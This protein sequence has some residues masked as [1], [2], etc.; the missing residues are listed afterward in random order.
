MND[1]Y[2]QLQNRFNDCHDQSFSLPQNRGN[3]YFRSVCPRKG[4]L[5]LIEE[6]RLRQN[7]SVRSSNMLLPLG[8]SYCLS[9]HVNWSIRERDMHFTTRRGQCEF[10]YSTTTDGDA[11][12]IADEPVMVVNIMLC[13]NLLRSYFESFDL[14]CQ[15]TEIPGLPLGTEKVIYRKHSF[16]SCSQQLLRNLMRT[17]CQRMADKLRIQGKVLELVAFLLDQ[18]DLTPHVIDNNSEDNFA[19]DDD[20]AMISRAK[21]ILRSNLQSPPSLRRLARLVGTNETKLKRRFV[22]LCGTTAY[23]HLATCRMEK[24]C[25]LLADEKLTTSQIAEELGYAERTHFSRAFSRHFGFPPSLYRLK[26]TA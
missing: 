2:A 9:G 5:L 14:P 21:S 23:G 11:T 24:A 8:I 15:N 18:L 6:Y 12:Y 25:E 16:P 4:M 20:Y 22:S 26:K 17:S 19:S 1:L 3:G 13:P 10:L 7:L